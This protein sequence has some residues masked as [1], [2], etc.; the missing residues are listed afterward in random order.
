LI[1]ANGDPAQNEPVMQELAVSFD[2]YY[3]EIMA[4][5]FPRRLK[6]EIAKRYTADDRRRME[7]MYDA[8]RND[9]LSR[10]EVFPWVAGRLAGRRLGGGEEVFA[11]G[12]QA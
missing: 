5:I 12:R 9:N 4:C 10:Q 7:E 6:L 8:L 2:A 3:D 1:I 11:R